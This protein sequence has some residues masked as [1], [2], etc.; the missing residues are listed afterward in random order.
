MDLPKVVADIITSCNRTMEDLS[1]EYEMIYD[2]ALIKD[3]KFSWESHLV[4][5]QYAKDEELEKT[6]IKKL[7]YLSQCKGDKVY[8]YTIHIPA[9]KHITVFFNEPKNLTILIETVPYMGK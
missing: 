8:M 1:K 5:A 9:K 2:V 7:N 4:S 6:V 3:L